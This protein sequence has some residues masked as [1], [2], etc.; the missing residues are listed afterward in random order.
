MLGYTL[1]IKVLQIYAEI[2][3]KNLTSEWCCE[4]KTESL[5]NKKK[6]IPR[7]YIFLRVASDAILLKTIILYKTD[8]SY[9]K[10]IKNTGAKTMYKLKGN[11]QRY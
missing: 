8:Y 5:V 4:S 9:S 6:I 11:I 3:H 10:K 7:F 2:S 1:A